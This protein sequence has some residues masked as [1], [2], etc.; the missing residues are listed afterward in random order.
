[1]PRPTV[2][3]RLPEVVDA[4]VQVFSQKGYEA[5]Q[6]ADIAGV[7]GMGAGAL[8][9]YVESK[10]GLFALCLERLTLGEAVLDSG[11]EL[12]FA[13]HSFDVTLREVRRHAGRLLHLPRLTAAL[14]GPVP[15]DV[16]EELTAVVREQYELVGGT[17]QLADMVERSARD[18]P[19]LAALF[20]EEWRDHV[21]RR[22]EAYLRARIEG[23]AFHPVDDV[24]VAA[25]FVV[26][27]IT[28]FARHRF[29]DR[30]GWKLDERAT[31]ATVVGLIVRAFL[32]RE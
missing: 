27:T 17:R 2:A 20:Y 1:M 6:M 9:N 21:L 25:R 11:L 12:P 14:A 7:L 10:Q 4:A 19:E 13:G 29:H 28:W 24:G 18:T 30:D 32:P 8:Y 5:T 26:E 22:L 31:E 15:A 3:E 23:G 16:E